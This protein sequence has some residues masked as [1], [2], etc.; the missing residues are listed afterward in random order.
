MN[1][2]RHNRVI[3]TCYADRGLLVGVEFWKMCVFI[4]AAMT[5]K[6]HANSVSLTKQ[7]PAE[8]DLARRFAL[9]DRCGL[10]RN[11][12]RVSRAKALSSLREICGS[13][14]GSPCGTLSD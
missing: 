8:Q 6:I 9:R 7:M 1:S 13:L 10:E 11:A 12:T 3:S 14:R 2:H 4:R 5:H